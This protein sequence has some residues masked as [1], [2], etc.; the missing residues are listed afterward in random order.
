MRR[1]SSNVRP[2]L[3]KRSPTRLTCDGVYR[4]AIV[5]RATRAARRP[6]PRGWLLRRGPK[7]TRQAAGEGEG[8]AVRAPLVTARGAFGRAGRRC[9][10]RERRGA[11]APLGA[12]RKGD[13]QEVHASSLPSR[14]RHPGG[15]SPA[16]LLKE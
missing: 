13:I 8:R 12:V 15:A 10:S 9:S 14:V 4:D 3:V 6:S 16:L 2:S 11:E 7:A 1:T 5:G